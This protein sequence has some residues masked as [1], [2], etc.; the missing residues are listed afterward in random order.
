ME[1]QHIH[2]RQI[3]DSR[4]N[5]TVEADVTLKDGSIGRA[6]VPSGASTGTHE[7][8]EL[9]DG[10]KAKYGGKGVTKAVSHVNSEITQALVGVN[11]GNQKLVDET[12]IALD[13]T[14][15]KSRL[16]ANAILAVSLATAKAVAISEKIPLYEYFGQLAGNST[17]TL[18]LPMMNIINGGAHADFATDIQEFMILP[19]GATSFSEAVRMG[20]EIFHKLKTVLKNKGYITTVGDEG[21]FAPLVKNGN[22]EA[23]DLISQA[24]E[25][26]GYKLGTDVALGLDIAAS[27]FYVNGFYELKRENQTKSS[28]EMV[29]WIEELRNRYPIILI[30]DGLSESDWDGWK[31]L[32]SR[33][34]DNTQIVGDDLLVTNTTFLKR[35]IREKAGNAI[36]IK[37][38]QIG[39]LTETINA[40]KMAHSAGWNAIISHR[41]GETEDTTIA[42][43]VV[44]LDT[45][46]IKTGSLSRTDRVAKYNQLLRIEEELGTLARFA[47]SSIN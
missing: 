35:A 20:S 24:V 14:E 43:L 47:T 39:T 5:P 31:L 16:G 38:N 4:G 21:G 27:E 45:G 37:V 2:A 34:G 6:G 44:G 17:F 8:I 41:S 3:L 15:N 10:D 25:L 28:G 46:Q 11:A 9:R 30:E 40:V 23:L 19:I 33:I 1:I 22:S 7:A 18:P 26:A 13:G 32:T 42:D 12:M 29:T 36:L